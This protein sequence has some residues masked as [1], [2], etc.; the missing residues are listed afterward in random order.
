M[1]TQ[2]PVRRGHPPHPPSVYTPEGANDVYGGPSGQC[3]SRSA[4]GAGMAG[5]RFDASLSPAPGL[6]RSHF[7]AS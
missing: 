4:A 3:L 1:N 7:V 2:W 6:A 5:D